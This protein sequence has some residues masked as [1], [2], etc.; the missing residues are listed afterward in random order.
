MTDKIENTVSKIDEI[1]QN[2]QLIE[3]PAMLNSKINKD[4]HVSQTKQSSDQLDFLLDIPLEVTVE[5]GRTKMLIHDLLKLGHGSIIQL[6]K[7][8]GE[9]LEIFANQKLIARGEVVSVDDCYGIR[10]TEILSPQERIEK[11]K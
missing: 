10:L 7:L 5:L 11:L 3:N 4:N 2:D 1:S 6:S 9:P 8:S